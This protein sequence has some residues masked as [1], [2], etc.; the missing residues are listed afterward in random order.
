VGKGHGGGAQ[1][2]SGF[3]GEREAEQLGGM[4]FIGGGEEKGICVG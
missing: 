2:A 4:D 3:A 1:Q